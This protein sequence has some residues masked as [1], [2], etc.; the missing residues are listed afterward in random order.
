MI[1]KEVVSSM[2]GKNAFEISFKKSQKAVT[3]DA[4]QQISI[5]NEPLKVDPQLLF[6]RLTIAAQRFSDNLPDAF[7]YGLCDVPS[8]LF[9]SD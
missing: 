7:T 3:L 2:A 4:A 9:C 8:S 5:N 1:G 6:Q